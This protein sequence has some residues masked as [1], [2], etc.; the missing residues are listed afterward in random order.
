MNSN[1]SWKTTL[2]GWIGGA[3]IVVARIDSIESAS[4]SQIALTF[5]QALSFFALAYYAK[6]KD[7]TGVSK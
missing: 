3:L 5:L 4:A 2:C 6:D 1:K 7:K